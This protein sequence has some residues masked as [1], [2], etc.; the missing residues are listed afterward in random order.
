MA[1]LTPSA[2]AW[3]RFIRAPG[4][5]SVR[6]RA[7]L[8]H[9]G[10]IHALA[11]APE[12]ALRAA[13]VPQAALVWLRCPDPKRLQADAV[14]LEQPHHHLLTCDSPDFPALLQCS[15]RAP[16]ALFVRGDPLWLW[17][18]QIAIVGSRNPTAGGRSNARDFARALA[19]AGLIVTSGLADGIDAVAH[20]AALDAGQPSVAVIG[21][22]PDRVY[23]ACN[24]ALAEA[25]ADHGAIVSEYPPGTPVRREHFPQRNRIIAGL[26]LGT[27][28]VEAA[29]RSGALISAR[30]AAEAGREVFA[31]PGSIHNPLARGCH[32]LIREGAALVESAEEI[33]AALGP[34]AAQLAQALHLRLDAADAADVTTNAPD[35]DADDA[36][37]SASVPARRHGAQAASRADT[38]ATVPIEARS[39]EQARLLAALGHDPV[40][41]EV[42]AERT[43][44]TVATLSSML[45]LM[46]LEGRVCAA[47]GRYTLG[48]SPP[49]VRPPAED[50]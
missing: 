38:L 11:A 34:Q 15:P 33:L 9:F 19:R 20:R 17:H 10:S 4:L 43:G 21:T 13:G 28:V 44:L 48:S 31:L 49:M 23:P 47:H 26:S 27:L 6:L 1:S 37:G 36:A 3:L 25:I 8:E 42:L 5:G 46:E 35:D 2:T 40:P 39:P 30:E 12:A 18:A 22:G 24:Q 14:W 32:R 7:L 16:A 29:L 45:I 50:G 41:V